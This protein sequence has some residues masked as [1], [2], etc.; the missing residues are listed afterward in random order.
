MFDIVGN[1]A[2]WLRLGGW[3][4]EWVNGFEWDGILHPLQYHV[5]VGH[6][7]SISV[8]NKKAELYNFGGVKY[9]PKKKFYQ[10]R[11]EIFSE[12]KNNM[13]VVK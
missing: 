13:S 9:F 3:G 8:Q 10:Y 7:M 2:R 1:V 12:I 5:N 6:M 4:N 11:A